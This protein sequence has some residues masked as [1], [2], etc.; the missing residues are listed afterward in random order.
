MLNF[1]LSV[2]IVTSPPTQPLSAGPRVIVHQVQRGCRFTTS[3]RPPTSLSLIRVQHKDLI[4]AK[5]YPLKYM[6][7][8]VHIHTLQMFSP[9]LITTEGGWVRESLEGDVNFISK[10]AVC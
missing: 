2:T 6:C 7:V 3:K 10:A 8:H 4:K 1:N 9:A 5:K